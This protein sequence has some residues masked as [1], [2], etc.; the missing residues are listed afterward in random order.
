MSIW[1]DLDSA[2]GVAT[3][4]VANDA[5]GVLNSLLAGV[6]IR[7]K[8]NLGPAF[9]VGGLAHAPSTDPAATPTA[10]TPGLL[11]FLGIKYSAQILGADGSTLVSVGDP[12]DTNYALVA[13]YLAVSLGFSYVFWRG[14][15]SFAK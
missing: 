10:S 8:T 13:A 12:P 1:S 4:A 3:Q 9:T 6:D 15:R 7:V 2:F 14:L 11:D 5:T